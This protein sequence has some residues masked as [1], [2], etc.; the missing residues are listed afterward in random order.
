MRSRPGSWIDL[1]FYD[2]H[3]KVMKTSD[4]AKST[5][6]QFSFTHLNALVK[7]RNQSEID[8]LIKLAAHHHYLILKCYCEILPDI[9]NHFSD[10]VS[11]GETL[12]FIYVLEE[13]LQECD[14]ESYNWLVVNYKLNTRALKTSAMDPSN[15]VVTLVIEQ[16]YSELF[17]Y[18]STSDNTSDNTNL[19]MLGILLSGVLLTDTHTWEK[20]SQ[21]FIDYP[22][23]CKSIKHFSYIL[24]PELNLKDF[25][26]DIQQTI[27]IFLN[28]KW[29]AFNHNQALVNLHGP[30]M[31][32]GLSIMNAQAY[33]CYDETTLHQRN[34]LFFNS[35]LDQLQEQIY[36]ARRNIQ[37]KSH[38][39]KDLDLLETSIFIENVGMLQKP[40]Q[41]QEFFA[42]VSNEHITQNKMRELF[43]LIESKKMSSL[44]GLKVIG[45][46]STVYLSSEELAATLGCINDYFTYQFPEFS[47][48][49]CML[50]SNVGHTLSVIY[51]ASRRTFTHINNGSITEYKTEELKGLTYKILDSFKSKSTLIL[52]TDILVAGKDFKLLQ[53]AFNNITLIHLFKRIHSC[54]PERKHVLD[55]QG[56]S[57]LCIAVSHEVVS[58]VNYLLSKGCDPNHHAHN[59]YSPLRI[60]V[61]HRNSVIVEALLAA[62]AN[63][64]W[65]AK[66]NLSVLDV[67]RN[68]G[69]NL[70]QEF[71]LDLELPDAM[72]DPQPETYTSQVPRIA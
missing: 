35:T 59:L 47:G 60:A 20:L 65:R 48:R 12:P 57:W 17:Q 51:D 68:T 39:K 28:R 49:F 32:Q 58:T 29:M 66:D 6:R 30:G 41:L 40:R 34:T 71:P 69:F 24:Y 37:N 63:I 27:T 67:A 52:H 23:L 13:L 44:G 56:S 10:F 9:A 43:P 38:S 3:A 11:C 7:Q 4:N 46:Y 53:A 33:L 72:N 36:L 45:N 2:S 62:G 18:L 5:P 64:H 70:N 50:M 19:I 15:Y 14:Y 25:N 1:L 8:K 55:S 31:C 21:I 54:T 61:S 26:S 16:R 22:N 42:H